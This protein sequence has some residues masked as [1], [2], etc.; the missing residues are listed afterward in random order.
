MADE[1]KDM[2]A[3][4][5]DEEL[6]RERLF[7]LWDTYGVYVIAAAAL[8]VAGVAGW[9]YYEH[10]QARASEVASTQYIIALNKFAVKQPYEAQ[11]AMEELL[12]N[13]P[14][15]YAA[16]ARLRLAAYDGAEGNAAEALAAYEKV[17]QDKSVDPMLADFARLQSAMLKFDNLSFTEL[18]N[19]LSRLA[20][21]KSP[22]RFSAREVLGLGAAKAGLN[23]EAR[24]HFKRLVDDPLTPP[25]ISERAKVMMAV[26]A[27]A[28]RAKAAP[29]PAKDKAEAP[30]KVEPMKE[31]KGKTVPGG[32]KTK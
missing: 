2:M 24:N 16:L 28:E 30:A 13:A 18:K 4:E 17:A 20:T 9:K 26:L 25:G 21:D 22:W 10:Q 6:R 8:V 14:A 7:K 19:Q 12:T 29:P 15:G 3:R 5:I 23:P 11:K 1:P 31:D 27:E 32:S